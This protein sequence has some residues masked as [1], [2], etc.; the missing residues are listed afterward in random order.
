MTDYPEGAIA[1]YKAIEELVARVEAGE[2][3]FIYSVV[4]EVWD[5]TPHLKNMERGVLTG[6][7]KE[8]GGVCKTQIDIIG[9]DKVGT[10]LNLP[11]R[12]IKI[13]TNN[14][15]GVPDSYLFTNYWLAYAHWLRLGKPD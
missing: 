14:N 10:Y 6:W 5:G 3:I 2:E 7:R 13:T 12:N 11:P 1:S 9:P 4:S 8:P 15:E